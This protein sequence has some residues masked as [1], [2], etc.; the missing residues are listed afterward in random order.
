MATETTA[1]RDAIE[2]AAWATAI[3]GG[4]VLALALVAEVVRAGRPHG[5]IVGLADR[6][7][8]S[9]GRRVAVALLTVLSAAV[10]TLGPRGAAADTDVR[11]WLTA[12]ATAS[13]PS[14][15][16]GSPGTAP[17]DTAP[18]VDTSPTTTRPT[19]D[20][21]GTRGWLTAPPTSPPARSRPARPHDPTPPSTTI[22]APVPPPTA[23]PTSP[24]PSPS[25]TSTVPAPTSTT[26]SPR[27]RRAPSPTSPPA[28]PT[29]PAPEAPPPLVLEQP[30]TY[31]VVPGDCLW[32]IAARR[33]GSGATARAVDLGWRAIYAA[34]R[35]AV[36]PDPGL[37]HPGLVLTLPP[38]D[39]TP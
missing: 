29:T 17:P 7:T 22:P 8:P 32:S 34:N 15:P 16:E 2:V 26:R 11:D 6:L 38:L 24:R 4:A 33:L 31:T 21:G 19:P 36:G 30:A 14:D 12:P 9:V 23:A 5:W 35:E 20:P 25:T 10:A 3:T 27:V 18:S 39:P 13:D 1:L 37:I 28:P